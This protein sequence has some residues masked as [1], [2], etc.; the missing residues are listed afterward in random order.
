[1]FPLPIQ[2]Q[3]YIT[4]EKDRHSNA[5]DE[6]IHGLKNFSKEFQLERW[7]EEGMENDSWIAGL[8]GRS[9]G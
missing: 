1:M 9:E 7:Y 2:T 8:R 4:V 5:L 3:T 6:G